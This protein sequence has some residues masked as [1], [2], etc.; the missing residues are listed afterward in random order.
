MRALERGKYRH[1]RDFGGQVGVRAV[2]EPK[3]AR[4]A[5]GAFRML[6][7]WACL[8]ENGEGGV[9]RAATYV[10]LVIGQKGF[11]RWPYCGVVAE[12]VWI[13]ADILPVCFTVRSWDERN[14]LDA[15]RFETFEMEG[16][17]EV[18]VEWIWP[19]KPLLGQRGLRG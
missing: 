16:E 13:A 11:V 1:K 18:Y 6:G 5:S 7:V 4:E 10:R 3:H 14:Q 8:I 17:D 12:Q 15:V 9:L 2:V 19:I